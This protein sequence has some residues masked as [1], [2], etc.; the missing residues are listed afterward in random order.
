[1]SAKHIFFHRLTIIAK[2]K[3]PYDKLGTVIIDLRKGPIQ[4]TKIDILKMCDNDVIMN[5]A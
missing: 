2:N 5:V 3:K 1:M 4:Y